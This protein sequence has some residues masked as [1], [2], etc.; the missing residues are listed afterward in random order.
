MRELRPLPLGIS[1]HVSRGL[2]IAAAATAVAAGAMPSAGATAP[3][4][5]IV[6]ARLGPRVDWPLL[7]VASGSG[8]IRRLPLGAPGASGPAPSPDG[9]RLAF[10]GGRPGR[11][12]SDLTNGVDLYVAAAD[13]RRAQRLTRTAANEAAPSWSPSGRQIAFVRYG[14]GNGSSLWVVG[15]NGRRPRRLT[16]GPTDIQP[17]W[18][19][20]GSEIA[21]VRIS[22]SY[23]SQIWVVRPDGSHAH[24]ILVHLVA[25]TDPQWSADGKT[26]LLSDG[27]TLFTVRTNGSAPRVLVTLTT[28]ARGGLE[29]PQPSWSHDGRGIAAARPY[30]A[31]ADAATATPGSS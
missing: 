17:A 20:R 8:R 10:V 13:G 24:R 19:P 15:A 6:F 14:A 30:L 11:D 29:D 16:A 1:G 23:E 31:R 27:E 28:D 26:L 18:S 3:R 4:P 5:G 7:Y 2:V 21:F 9:T 25:A 12:A 22:R